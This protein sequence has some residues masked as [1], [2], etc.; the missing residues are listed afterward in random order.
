MTERLQRLLDLAAARGL[1]GVILVPGPSLFYLTGLSFHLSERLTL[2]FF[3]TGGKAALVLPALE[4]EK[5]AAMRTFPYDD[6]QGPTEALHRAAI[7]LRGEGRWGVEGWRMRFAEAER[8]RGAGF[9]RLE[10]ADDLFAE[11]RMRKQA[12]EI[13]AMRRS[14][15]VAEAAFRRWVPTLRTGMTEREAA[16]ALIAE[17][18]TGGADGLSFDPIVVGGAKAALPHAVPGDR[19]FRQGDW[20][21]VDWG[22]FV[23][24]Y[25]S[26]ITRMVVFGEPRGPLAAV[27]RIVLDANRAG[28]A[29]IRP[30]LPAGEVDRAARQVIE[31]AGYGD[32]FIHRTGHGLG[33][34]IHEPPYIVGSASTRLQAGMTFTVEPGIY[35]PEIGGVRIEDD[36]LVTEEGAETLTT[37]SREPWIV[38]V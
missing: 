38:A 26:D 10:A 30:G 15:A 1:T 36:I 21:V 12:E 5:A 4:A 23:D 19:P 29:A 7:W 3:T 28:R 11:L 27:H 18:L 25:A 8:L 37:L 6:L 17:M 16:A 14:I 34:E 13:A 22:V 9:R 35:L 20:V 33:L 2:A 32:R 24:G 31:A